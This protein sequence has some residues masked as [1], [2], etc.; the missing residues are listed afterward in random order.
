MGALIRGEASPARIAAELNEPLGNVGYHV[1][2]LE[3]LGCIELVETRP[4]Q[5]G[6]VVEHIY[7]AVDRGLIDAEAWEQFGEKEKQTFTTTLMRL[8]SEDVSDAMLEGTFYE[9]DDN[10]L[11]RTPMTLDREGWD[12]T[13]AVLDET[14]DRLL[15]IEAK[16]A[17]RAAKTDSAEADP[18]FV[19]VL[20][21]QFRSPRE[22]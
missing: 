4:A 6:R 10:H 11:S 13:T 14:L 2:V 1:G 22:R 20:M 17:A 9:P 12:E 15:E 7:R 19:T 21:F 8:A 5:G 18:M 16:A 3:E